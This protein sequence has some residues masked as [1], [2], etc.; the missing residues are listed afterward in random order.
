VP[1]PDKVRNQQPDQY[2]E[3]NTSRQPIKAGPN[4]LHFAFQELV[5]TAPTII[6]V[7]QRANLKAD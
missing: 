2:Q 5:Q 3:R 4:R 1:A 6:D 7:E